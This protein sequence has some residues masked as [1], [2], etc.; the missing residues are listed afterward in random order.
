MF[1]LISSIVSGVLSPLFSWLNKRE[2]VSLE[3]FKVNGQVDQSLLNA[4]IESLRARRDVLVEG[5]KYRGFRAMQYFFV[6]PLCFWWTAI[7]FQCVFRPYFPQIKTVLALPDPL[8]EW[9]GG[10]IAFLFL[11]SKIDNWVRK[12]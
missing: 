1:E 10:M 4:H 7:V 3:K 12:T 5:M 8:N 2:D 9:A 11:T 6:Y